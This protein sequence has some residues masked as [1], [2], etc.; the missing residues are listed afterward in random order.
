[1]EKRDGVNGHIYFESAISDPSMWPLSDIK[2][3]VHHAHV[4]KMAVPTWTLDS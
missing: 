2:H 3:N 1:M 4:F